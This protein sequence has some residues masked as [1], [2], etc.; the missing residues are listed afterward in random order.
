MYLDAACMD[1]EEAFRTL[2]LIGTKVGHLDAHMTVTG[3]A[4]PIKSESVRLHGDGKPHHAIIGYYLAAG[5]ATDSATGQSAGRRRYSAMRVVRSSDSSSTLLMNS[6]ITNDTLT[7][8][9]K[10]YRAGGDNSKDAEPLFHFKLSDA[11]VKTFTLMFGGAL[12][13][14]GAVEIIEFAF[15][16]IE[17]DAS[18]QSNT[19]QS[20]AKNS[21]ED[22]WSGQ[23]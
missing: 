11:R 21:F 9:L 12:P 18:P 15:R 7:V 2:Q 4:G 20:G 5:G 3:R 16:K 17:G 23:S 6:F 19:G 1:M 22:D 10:S 14:T 13:N 8:E